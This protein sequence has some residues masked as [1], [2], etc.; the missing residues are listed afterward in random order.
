MTD[1]L[2]DVS[3]PIADEHWLFVQDVVAAVRVRDVY[4]TGKQPGKTVLSG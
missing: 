2:H 3:N 1:L 4:G